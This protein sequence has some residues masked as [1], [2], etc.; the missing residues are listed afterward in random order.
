MY[1]L[2]TNICIY[3]I[4]RKP[5]DVLAILRKKVKKEIYVSSITIAELEY[6]IAKSVYPERNK[7]ALIEFL[8][9]FIILP[10][11]GKDAFEYGSIR[12]SL[13]KNGTPIGSMDLLLASQARANNLI[14][15]TNNVKEFERV[16]GL[17]IE[18]WVK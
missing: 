4:K 15:V 1:L 16:N 10:F 6:G 5:I 13:E 8:S 14:L 17:T 2:D 3:I 18:N 12:S 7:I 9:V 11:T